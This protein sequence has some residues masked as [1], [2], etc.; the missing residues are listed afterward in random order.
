M[1]RLAWPLRKTPPEGWAAECG[2]A[3][4]CRGKGR[5]S[6]AWAHGCGCSPPGPNR[7]SRAGQIACAD[8]LLAR[9]VL[10]HLGDRRQSGAFPK[11]L[12]RLQR[13]PMAAKACSPGSEFFLVTE[14]GHSL[15]ALRFVLLHPDDVAL[16]GPA[17]ERWQPLG[18]EVG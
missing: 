7:V 17:G 5:F 18:A 16:R 2:R 11:V 12:R 10:V 1:V 15:F 13:F 3:Q 6:L 9:G 14:R 4:R 8:H